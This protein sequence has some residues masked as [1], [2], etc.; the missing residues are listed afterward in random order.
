MDF[1]GYFDV[2][3]GG[4][5]WVCVDVVVWWWGWCCVYLVVDLLGV[6]VLEGC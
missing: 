2:D 3:C 4:C 5:W 6:V 1:L